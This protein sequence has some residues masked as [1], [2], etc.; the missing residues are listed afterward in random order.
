M[1]KQL[2]DSRVDRSSILDA[3]TWNKCPQ[4][5]VQSSLSSWAET[6]LLFHAAR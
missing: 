1:R 6:V 3:S 2:V 4:S 5:T